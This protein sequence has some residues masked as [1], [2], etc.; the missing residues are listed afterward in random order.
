VLPKVCCRRKKVKRQKEKRTKKRKKLRNTGF[1]DDFL[2]IGVVGD[3]KKCDFIGLLC[4]RA[5]N[6]DKN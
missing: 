6:E 5:E 1:F 2:E 3:S 4:F